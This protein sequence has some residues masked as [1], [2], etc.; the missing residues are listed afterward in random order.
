MIG[1]E[2]KGDS[3]VLG[4]WEPIQLIKILTVVQLFIISSVLFYS[5]LY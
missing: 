5:I 4:E 2:K 1:S 3:I